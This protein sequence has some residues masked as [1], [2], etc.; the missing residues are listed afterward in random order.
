MTG[1]IPQPADYDGDLIT[2]IAVF[3][4]DANP[5]NNFW[6]IQRSSD[7]GLTAVEWGQNGDVPVTAAFV[8]P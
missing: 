4:P 8:A 2:D 1:D 5:V 7:S 3:R 6:Y